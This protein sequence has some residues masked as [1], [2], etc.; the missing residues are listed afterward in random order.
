MIWF[1]RPKIVQL[2]VIKQNFFFPV[3]CFHHTHLLLSQSKQWTTKKKRFCT[4]YVCMCAL[5]KGLNVELT[6]C[7]KLCLRCIIL[8]F[9]NS[10]HCFDLNILIP[11]KTT[12]E[13][14]A[15]RLPTVRLDV[16][17]WVHH[18]IWIIWIVAI[19]RSVWV[20]VE[21]HDKAISKR[22]TTQLFGACLHSRQ[23]SST[24][25]QRYS[26]RKKKCY[27]RDSNWR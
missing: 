20:K 23:F 10:I 21:C 17:Q 27:N 15:V 1:S 3:Y 13:Q 14:I 26:L 9:W 19:N 25:H 5:D 6:G 12:W 24:Y 8:M 11:P 16:S 2:I 18:I 4:M 22:Q 7:Y